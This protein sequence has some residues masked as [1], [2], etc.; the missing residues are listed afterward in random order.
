MINP[1]DY[2]LA[3]RDTY[4]TFKVKDILFVHYKCPQ[5]EK[6]ASLWI[7]HNCIS[8]TINGMKTF[9]HNGKSWTVAENTSLF[10]RKTAF[11]EMLH[12]HVGWEVMGFYFND[13]FLRQVLN[14]YRGYFSLKKLPPVST[15][16]IMEI[17]VNETIR[18]FFYSIIPYFT[19]K[20]PPSE[21]LLELKFKE[22]LFNIF[23]V[24]ANSSLL[25]YAY[26][27]DQQNGTPLW[28]V[29]ESNYMFNLTIAEFA[30]L[31][32]RSITSFNKV[33]HDY[34]H[35]T[36]GKWLTNRRLE[37]AR[38]LLRSSKNNIS[39]IAYNSGFEN[40]SH[41]S[42]IFKEKYLLSPLQ[43]RKSDQIQIA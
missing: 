40:I 23:M 43:Y 8:Y 27:I 30:R 38:L 14:E 29:I 28:Q 36:P 22:L 1:Y 34:Y 9:L 25:S 2:I 35:A 20:T 37:H 17:K 39:E 15:D 6:Q 7:H 5:V 13:D 21:G 31:S 41:F 32:N 42:R 16:M 33:F 18:A 10:I 19:Q 3:N 24:P 26:F 11:T 4:K 12:E